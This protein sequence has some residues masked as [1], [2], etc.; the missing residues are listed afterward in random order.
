MALVLWHGGEYR[1]ATGLSR[2]RV[3]RRDLTGGRGCHGRTTKLREHDG[4]RMSG[5]ID[6]FRQHADEYLARPEPS[7]VEVAPASYIGIQGGGAPEDMP[8]QGGLAAL[9]ALAFTLKSVVR[10]AAG[11][12]FAVGKLE[13]LWWTDRPGAFWQAP[14]SAWRWC[15][16]IRVPDMVDQ[17]AIEAARAHLAARRRAPDA[18]RAARVRLEEGRCLQVLHVGPYATEP[19]SIAR[20]EQAA[21][22]AGMAFAGH[23]HEIY[24][25]DPRRTVATKLR[26]ILRRPVR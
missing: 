20:L 23:H 6:L 13:A 16:L 15:L 18:A 7:V 5:K 19:E 21:T 1:R 24:L 17:P 9:F 3:F 11:Y 12:D 26:T 25:S 14:R 2:D 10:E 4:R 22:A 8:F